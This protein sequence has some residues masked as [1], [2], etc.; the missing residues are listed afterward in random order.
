MKRL[1][2]PGDRSQEVTDVQSRLRSLGLEIDDESGLF[3][4]STKQAVRTF[5]QRRQILIDGIVGPN[6]WDE[7]VEASWRLGDRTLYLTNPFMRGDDVLALQSRLNALGFDAGRADGIFGPDTDEAIRSFQKEYGVAE[8]GIFGIATHYAL[9]GLRVD[10]PGT[11]AALREELKRA[12]HSGLADALVIIDPG[13]GGD[14]EGGHTTGGARE[15]D[16][17]WDLAGRVAARLAGAGARVRFTRTEIEGPDEAERARRANELGGDVFVSVHLNS[18][19]EGG[20]GGACTYF[21]GGSPTGEALADNIQEELVR[22]GIEDCRTHA[23]S[24]PILKQTRMPAVLVEPLFITN[25]AEEKMLEDPDFRG[26]LAAAVATGIR[27]Y[28]T[29]AV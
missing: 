2:R 20:A 5:Q 14:D 22:L 27:N 21:F 10:R 15:G 12:E 6:T 24:Y 3:G 28:F 16:L 25:P 19:H 1:I 8:D 23:R 4:E 29:V 26:A 18:H 17:C 11:A 7:L 9:L 13:H